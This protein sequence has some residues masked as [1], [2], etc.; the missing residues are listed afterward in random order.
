MQI[1]LRDNEMQHIFSA[2]YAKMDSPKFDLAHE[3]RLHLP[4]ECSV[5]HKQAMH[6]YVHPI[7]LKSLDKY[8]DWLNGLNK[9]DIS[10][11]YRFYKSYLCVIS[12]CKGNLS[13]T[14]L[15]KTIHYF[16][17]EH[18]YLRLK[19]QLQT[20]HIV[21]CLPFCLYIKVMSPILHVG[22]GSWW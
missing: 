19:S 1:K 21:K 8:G 20:Y 2:I 15:S 14:F 16:N 12:K 17:S 3:Y 9:D 22:H 7:L 4:E 18:N 6:Y 10:E 13:Y 5:I 11:I